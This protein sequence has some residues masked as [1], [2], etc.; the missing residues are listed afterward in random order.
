MNFSGSFVTP[1]T[2]TRAGTVTSLGF[3]VGSVQRLSGAGAVD[4]ISETTALTTTGANALTLA[5][6]VDGQIKYII[7]DVAGG[8]GT[9]TPTTKTGFTTVTFTNAA[10]CVTLKFLT[11]RGWYVLASR[12]AVVA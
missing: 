10:D 9:L 3:F 8:V 7:L 2:V 1:L 11:T 6:G 4:V 5:N 12:G